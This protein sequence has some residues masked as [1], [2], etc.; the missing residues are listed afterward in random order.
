MTGTQQ[1]GGCRCVNLTQH[2]L[3]SARLLSP[4]AQMKNVFF[5]FKSV[6]AMENGTKNLENRCLDKGLVT[7]GW[8]LLPFKLGLLDPPQPTGADSAQCLHALHATAIQ[9]IAVAE[10]Q[11]VRKAQACHGRG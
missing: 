4:I 10:S 1:A 3:T 7:G 9:D 2:A 5:M 11:L 6:L 8:A